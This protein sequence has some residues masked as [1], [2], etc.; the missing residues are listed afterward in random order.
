MPSIII[1]D[2]AM[3]ARVGEKLLGVARRN[4]A[5][6]GFVC[7][8]NGVCQTCQCRVLSGAEQLSPPSEAEQAWMPPRRLAEGHRLACQAVIR[9]AGPVRI[10]TKAEELRR[11]TLDVLQPRR[12]EDWRDNTEPLKENLARMIADQL[13]RYPWNMLA[14]LGRVGPWRFTYPVLDE[15]RYADDTGRVVRKMLS[16]VERIPRSDL[17]RRVSPVRPVD[18]GAPLTTPVAVE[19]D[20]TLPP[21]LDP[22]PAPPPVNPAAVARAEQI[23]AAARDLRRAREAIRRYS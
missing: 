20:V 22:A 7:D 17:P 2:V 18:P 1:N 3:E 14:A 16:G 4:A 5:H 8:G 10:V 19:V 6:I 11:Q 13:R 21:P 12:D 15:D 9:G 23:L